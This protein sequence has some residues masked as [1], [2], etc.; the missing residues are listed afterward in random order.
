MR[1]ADHVPAKHLGL[2][3]ECPA[4]SWR[5]N[6]VT[7]RPFPF[8]GAAQAVTDLHRGQLDRLGRI[9]RVRAAVTREA[10]SKG[11]RQRQMPGPCCY[12]P[13]HFT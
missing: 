9:A 5:H 7:A 10:G 11:P 4:I 1:P 12:T 13:T 8:R 3:G 6:P 2:D